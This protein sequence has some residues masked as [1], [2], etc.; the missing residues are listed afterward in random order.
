MFQIAIIQQ[1]IEDAETLT[2]IL[3]QNY[4]PLLVS[5]EN[6]ADIFA[7]E[8]VKLVISDLSRVSE[9][10]IPS[11]LPL[12]LTAMNKEDAYTAFSLGAVGFLLYPYQK[13]QVLQI[14]EHLQDLFKI[15]CK[16]VVVKTFGRF[17]VMVD[18][19]RLHF[20]NAK[21]KELLALLIDRRGGTVTM[22][23]AID[24]LWENRQYDEAVKQLYRKALRYIKTLL[25]EKEID[26]L[27]INR[28]SCSIDPEAITCDLYQLFKNDPQA[29][30][31]FDGE[32]MID[33]SW[34]EMRV[35]WITRHLGNQ[36]LEG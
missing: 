29:I 5:Q 15:K 33:Y 14:V 34:G 4:R 35:A 10:N 11:H 21:A 13:E 24:V 3:Q 26:F 2:A 8:E 17:D 23:E 20:S 18:G 6:A 30:K 1:N 27:V 7:R 22:A 19:Q 28:G 36:Y 31:Q 32:Y 25:M 9:I 16:R 12:I